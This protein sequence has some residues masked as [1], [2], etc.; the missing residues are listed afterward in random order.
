MVRGVYLPGDDA[1]PMRRLAIVAGILQTRFT[2]T[3]WPLREDVV[4]RAHWLYTGDEMRSYLGGM[5]TALSNAVDASIYTIGKESVD[6]RLTKV[7]GA[8]LAE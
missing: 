8:W 1:T 2:D 6:I 4:I 7:V 5:D 3:P